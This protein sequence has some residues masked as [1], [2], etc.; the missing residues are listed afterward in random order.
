MA[1]ANPNTSPRIP[2]AGRRWLIALAALALGALGLTQGRGAYQT[3]RAGASF[4]ARVACSCRFVAGRPLSQC[5][6][7]FEPGMRMVF[8]SEDAE[9]RTV[10]ARVP[11]LASQSA[12]FHEQSGCVL[13][14]W[15]D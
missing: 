11:L 8:L 2:R 3:A 7:D 9:T 5:R 14:P 1:M 4:G 15:T 6:N 10:T 12:T 13:Q